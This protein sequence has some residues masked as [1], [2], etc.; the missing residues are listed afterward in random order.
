M[1]PALAAE[2]YDQKRHPIAGWQLRS[3]L[4]G[5]LDLGTAGEGRHGSRV[6]VPTPWPPIDADGPPA[7]VAL[8]PGFQSHFCGESLIKRGQ[9]K[10]RVRANSY[11]PRK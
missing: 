11:F 6:I 2:R 1:V 8:F 9:G 3:T 5:G 10:I 4:R 7:V